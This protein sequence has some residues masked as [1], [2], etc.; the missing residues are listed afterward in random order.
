MRQLFSR[1]GN[2]NPLVWQAEKRRVAEAAQREE[3]ARR[4]E[5]EA[6]LRADEA[7][8][9][10]AAAEAARA[11]QAQREAEAAALQ[12]RRRRYCNVCRWRLCLTFMHVSLPSPA[13]QE[14]AAA[15]GRLLAG[16]QQVVVAAEGVVKG[17]P[18]EVLDGAGLAPA[19]A[20]APQGGE[21]VA[22][23]LE[24]SRALVAAE[25]RHRRAAHVVARA[26]AALAAPMDVLARVNT[27][28]APDEERHLGALPSPAF[29][30][31]MLQVPLA[32]L[33]PSFVA[34]LTCPWLDRPSP[35]AGGHAGRVAVQ[36]G[37]WERRVTERVRAVD[38]GAAGG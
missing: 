8:A 27:A 33:F 16:L 37:P 11:V 12:V 21:S 7:R 24:R 32:A 19:P 34:A 20:L 26:V 1:P 10:A 36:R 5:E 4:R 25:E 38:R 14:R 29:V 22:G 15:A 17:V 30:D 35:G 18:A 2:L 31:G 23:L 6:R 28:L 13:R 9:V 3:E